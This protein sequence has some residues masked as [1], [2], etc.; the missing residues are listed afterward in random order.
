LGPHDN[1]TSISPQGTGPDE[2][3]FVAGY[4][5]AVVTPEWR[6]GVISTSDTPS[7]VAA[8]NGFLN[9]VTYFCGLCRQTYPPFYE[10]PLYVELPAGST[11]AEWQAAADV[12][13]DKFVKTVYVS[14]EA[15]SEALLN[16]LDQSGVGIIANDLPPAAL[17]S[18]WVASVQSDY[19]QALQDLWTELLNG[20]S[21][22]NVP[23]S[24]QLNAVN[25]DL[26]S[27]GRQRLVQDLL[28]DLQA[29]YVDT[30]VD[31]STGELR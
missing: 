29:G 30:G 10:Y 24:I 19:L 14:P 6:V 4:I 8:R 22:L 17:Q 9:G 20:N 15:S 31:P 3:A 5:A 13:R 23:A 26:F 7:G 2:I 27:P 16:Y 21:G 11:Q 1:L 25:P 18:H 12:L 28:Q